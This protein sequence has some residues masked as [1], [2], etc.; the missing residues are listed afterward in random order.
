[1]IE[2]GDSAIEVEIILGLHVLAHDSFSLGAKLL[3]NRVS[4]S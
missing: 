3:C 4:F 1:V 2:R